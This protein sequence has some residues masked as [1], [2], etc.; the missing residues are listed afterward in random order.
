MESIHHN[1]SSSSLCP[2]AAAAT[3][4]PTAGI[5][6]SSALRA[7]GVDLT[8]ASI[9]G[10]C[11]GILAALVVG[12]GALGQLSRSEEEERTSLLDRLPRMAKE[13]ASERVQGRG[14]TTY[15]IPGSVQKV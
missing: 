15:A 3:T 8:V 11:V 9:A 13:S 2:L 14:G 12:L 7:A 4:G 10:V 6:M 1:N 5:A